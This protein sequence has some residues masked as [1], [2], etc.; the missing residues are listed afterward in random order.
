VLFQTT[1]TTCRGFLFIIL[2]LQTATIRTQFTADVAV[3]SNQ[4]LYYTTAN[5]KNLPS[6]LQLPRLWQLRIKT[7]EVVILPGITSS[8]A[9]NP[10]EECDSARNYQL[11]DADSDREDQNTYKLQMLFSR[12]VNKFEYKTTLTSC[13]L[14]EPKRGLKI[15]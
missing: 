7:G 4:T 14:N 13:I 2:L 5:C 12:N 9:R 6:N 1:K 3:H 8:W 10:P 11:M 15:L